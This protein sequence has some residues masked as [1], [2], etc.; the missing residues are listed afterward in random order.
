MATNDLRPGQYKRIG[1]IAENNPKRADRV[2]E[3]MISRSEREKKGKAIANKYSSSNEVKDIYPLD[4][5][6]YRG[7]K[8][9]YVP[10]IDYNSINFKNK[11][12]DALNS[13]F[14]KP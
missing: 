13:K 14:Y 4:K 9:R 11:D 7:S 10:E 2:A 5:Q 3:R 12:I 6:V 1:R 8:N